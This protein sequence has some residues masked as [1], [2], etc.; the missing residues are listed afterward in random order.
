MKPDKQV[1]VRMYTS[2]E[3]QSFE[4]EKTWESRYHWD[5]NSVNIRRLPMQLVEASADT[6]DQ[7]CSTCRADA[8]LFAAHWG[9]NKG[10]ITPVLGLFTIELGETY[11]VSNYDPLWE[12]LWWWNYRILGEHTAGTPRLLLP[13]CLNALARHSWGASLSVPSN[14]RLAFPLLRIPQ[15]WT[16]TVS[17]YPFQSQ[18]AVLDW[19]ATLLVSLLLSDS[20]IYFTFIS[21][22]ITR[23]AAPVLSLPINLRSFHPQHIALS[24]IFLS[25]LRSVSENSFIPPPLATC[26]NTIPAASNYSCTFTFSLFFPPD[27]KKKAAFFF[28]SDDL[29]TCGF[30]PSR[31]SFPKFFSVFSFPLWHLQ[32][33]PPYFLF[34]QVSEYTYRC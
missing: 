3:N 1:R 25:R 5:Q 29:L 31:P 4:Q 8:G 24:L 32:L 17:L 13:P 33:F 16:P 2:H 12:K 19:I 20:F 9:N 34:F 27:L 14:R 23:V 21:W 15:S 26:Q 6:L 10:V 7:S 30:G 18:T 11:K 28:C 22:C